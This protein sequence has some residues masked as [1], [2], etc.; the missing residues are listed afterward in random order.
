MNQ[1]TPLFR[2]ELLQN[3]L[4]FKH[5]FDQIIT[6][7]TSKYQLSPT[8][9]IILFLISRQKNATI[10]S[11]QKKLHCNQGNMSSLCKKLNQTGYLIRYRDPMDERKVFLTLTEK[12]KNLLTSIQK[13]LDS[14]DLYIQQLPSYQRKE[15]IHGLESLVH[16]SNL[17]NSKLSK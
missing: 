14:L 8:S 12:G 17:V 11:I 10:G 5:N 15:A 2:I 4:R 7:I 13:D 3:M 6:K 16:I 9:V 1:N